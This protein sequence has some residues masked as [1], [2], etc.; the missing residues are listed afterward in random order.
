M[1][2]FGG[3]VGL[4]RG[5][6]I[7][8]GLGIS[9]DTSCTDHEI[10]KRVRNLAGLN[11]PGGALVDD[12]VYSPPDPPSVFAHP[13]CI[14]T[15]RNGIFIGEETPATGYSP[16]YNRGMATLATMALA[17]LLDV[18]ASDDPVPG[19]GSASAVAGALGASLLLMVAGMQKTRSG[20][21]EETADLA[22]AAARLRPLRDRL[23]ILADED[24]DAYSMVVAA[25]KLPKV[26][27]EEKAAR[28]EAIQAA[29]RQATDV[30]LET[31]RTCRDALR[32]AVIVARNGNRNA[33]S[34]IGVAVE[35]LQAGLK[36]AG[37][38]VDINL[39]GLTDAQ[40]V[41][42]VRWERQDLELTA[43]DEAGRARGLL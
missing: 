41:E 39:A 3:G 13:K 33:T 37:L 38:N 5:G 10:A 4:Y 16:I 26:S 28:K 20:T 31:M 40:Y 11:P 6:E 23:T 1:I 29:A 42:R 35:L 9:G 22:E 8:G 30:P 24:S 7:V 25:F 19:G 21:P 17:D 15:F 12:I 18:F 32:D 34:D 27:D 2:F 14:N 36:G 43:A